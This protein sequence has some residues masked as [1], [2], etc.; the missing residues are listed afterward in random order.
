MTGELLAVRPERGRREVLLV[1]PSVSTAG[2][3]KQWTLLAGPWSLTQTPVVCGLQGLGLLQWDGTE[4]PE[5]QG[6]V[7]RKECADPSS[8]E[9]RAATTISEGEVL[10]VD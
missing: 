7:L 5:V 9:A 10:A 8:S 3:F 2:V 6:R 1:L 4:A